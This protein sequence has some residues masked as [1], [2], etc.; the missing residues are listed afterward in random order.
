MDIQQ[1]INLA[2]FR[3]FERD[4]I[5]FAYPTQ[6]VYAPALQLERARGATS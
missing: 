2:I 4:E 3:R 1:A 6:T 5:D